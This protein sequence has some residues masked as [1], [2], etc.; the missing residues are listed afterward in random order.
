MKNLIAI[1]P[2][3]EHSERL[4]GKNFLE[5]GGKP[6]FHWVCNAILELRANGLDQLIITTD[7]PERFKDYFIKTNKDCSGSLII[8]PRPDCLRGDHVNMNMV[9]A[10]VVT[11]YPAEAY[12][13]THATSP[14]ITAQDFEQAYRYLLD[15]EQGFDSVCSMSMLH[16][17]AYYNGAPVNFNPS[18]NANDTTRLQPIIYENGAFY[19]F[20]RESFFRY[21]A[22]KCGNVGIKVLD[23]ITG[24][25]IDTKTDWTIAE[26]LASWKPERKIQLKK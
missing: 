6:L 23:H 13:Q 24:L 17:R 19:F 11:E 22:R 21:G 8:H 2:I 15:P 7:C 25:D 10:D 4:P 12:F 9:I 26:G 16:Q 1:L 5:L 14:F 18:N 3:K 20:K